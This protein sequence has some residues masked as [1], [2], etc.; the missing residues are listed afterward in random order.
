MTGYLLA[1]FL[2]G[3]GGEAVRFAVSEDA[4][5]LVFHALPGGPLRSDVGEGGARDPFL[6]RDTASGRIV[7][8][9]TDLRTE[10]DGDWH[11][12]ARHG[13]RS[14]LVWES[15]D[16]VDWGGPQ[17]RLV[18]PEDAGNA[19]APKAYR[20]EERG[21]WQ[22]F[23]SSAL[24]APGQDRGTAVHQR[25]LVVETE[26]FV[27]FSSARIALD[28]GRDV[29]DATFLP[30][31]DEWLRFTVETP[32]GADST[33]IT[34]ARGA[35]LDG[36]FETVRTGIGIPELVRGEGPA[37]IRSPDG[38]TTW[39]LIDEFGLRGYRLFSSARPGT[40]GFEPVRGA[41]LPDDARHGSLLALTDD[42]AAR[43]RSRAGIGPAP[44]GSSRG[45]GASW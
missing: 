13:S 1:Y 37:V 24:F 3:P 11:R 14:I 17:L 23:F 41:R 39:L 18:A 9:A 40:G 35:S 8:L 7:L 2:P 31:G 4:T 27:C 21:C 33:S 43:L 20:N 38:V 36:R 26:D 42:E 10:E 29:I 19:W 22:V 12:A 5:P 32:P 44:V 15:A 30:D 6:V 28:T 16:L 34:L 45:G 25:I